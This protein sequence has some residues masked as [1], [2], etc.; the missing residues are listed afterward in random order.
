[1]VVT[2]ELGGIWAVH[3]DR[4]VGLSAIPIPLSAAGYGGIQ[5][6]RVVGQVV[7]VAVIAQQGRNLVKGSVGGWQR[8]IDLVL[9][10]G[11]LGIVAV[12]AAKAGDQAIHVGSTSSHAGRQNFR[13]AG[14]AVGA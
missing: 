2:D 11:A 14:R 10:H 9:H 3:V 4:A 6:H 7:A 5:A 8:L 13:V 12:M 1:A